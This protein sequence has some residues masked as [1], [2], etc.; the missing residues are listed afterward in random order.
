[1]SILQKMGDEIV[2]LSSKQSLVLL[3]IITCIFEFV[4]FYTPALADAAVQAKTQSPAVQEELLVNDVLAKDSDIN[5]EAAKLT[6]PVLEP[7]LETSEPV[8]RDTDATPETAISSPQNP[9]NT[10]AQGRGR[11]PE[12]GPAYKVIN[13]SSHVIT[14]YNSEAAQTDDSPCITANGFNV[15][16]HGVEDTIAANFLKFGTKVKIPELFGDRIFIVRDRMN[17][18]YTSRVDVWMKEKKDALRF[19]VKVAQIQVVE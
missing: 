5:E 4:L 11:L 15:C 8:S 17:S 3:V 7:N 10:D 18:R 16:T 9:E 13:N 19:G 1:M 2:P 14:A 6:K 12:A